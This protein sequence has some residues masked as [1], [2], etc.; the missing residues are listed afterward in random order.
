VAGAHAKG[1]KVVLALGGGS[2]GD[3][4]WVGATA[5]ET[6]RKAL[7]KSCMD[8]VHAYKLDG[9]D[10]D[11]EY[12]DGAQV[13]GYNA[14]VKLLAAELHAEGKQISAAVTYNDWPKSFPDNQ[15]FGHFD[16]LNIMIYDNPPP[17]STVAH[18]NT[19]LDI[20]IDKKGLPKEKFMVGAPFYGPG[21][22]Y[23][24]IVAANPA[25]AWVDQ[26]GAEGYNSIP[27]M[28]KKTEI[29]L[30]K[31]GGMMFWQLAQDAPGDLSLL[32]AVHEVVI[33]AGPTGILSMKAV[34][35]GGRDPIRRWG[36]AHGMPGPS[37]SS[38]IWFDPAGRRL[39]EIG[40]RIP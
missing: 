40:L 24:E 7:V 33:K 38:W 1:V 10:F 19:S 26:N 37:P 22:Q 21:G 25:A 13:A 18:V 5:T 6:A 3:A 2:N 8:A 31:A 9:I 27:T 11:W 15:L 32:S 16:F 28:R 36:N 29:A 12:P 35:Q 23:R 34:K 30:A 4:G 14:A 20:W 39:D 17:H